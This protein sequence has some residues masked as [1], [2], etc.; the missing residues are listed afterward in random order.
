MDWWRRLLIR[1]FGGRHTVDGGAG[2]AVRE[3][4]QLR[5]RLRPVI[6]R[7]AELAGAYEQ[8]DAALRR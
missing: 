5:A 4:R 7:A 2:E 3:S 8:G 1:V 6:D